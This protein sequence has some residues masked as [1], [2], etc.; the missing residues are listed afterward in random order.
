M[1][2][3]RQLFHGLLT[4]V[5][6]GSERTISCAEFDAFIVDYLEGNLDVRERV[7]FERHL[8]ACDACHDYLTGYRQAMALGKAVFTLPEAPVPREVPEELVQAILRARPRS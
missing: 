3:I 4:K 8:E 6:G 5:F 7:L 2:S 1:R